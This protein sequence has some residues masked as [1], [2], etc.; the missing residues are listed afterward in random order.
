LKIWDRL[1]QLVVE[2]GEHRD[3]IDTE[4]LHDRDDGE[5]DACSDQAIFNGGGAGFVSQEIKKKFTSNSHSFGLRGKSP[6][7]TN[8]LAEPK[9]A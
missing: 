6:M 2:R 7:P 8:A 4:A 1:L 9:V 3:Q 5:R